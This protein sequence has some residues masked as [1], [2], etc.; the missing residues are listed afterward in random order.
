VGSAAV[1]R[2]SVALCSNPR[3]TRLQRRLRL[4]VPLPLFEAYL[5]LVVTRL[6]ERWF[7]SLKE[8]CVWLEN[9]ESSEQAKAAV[10]GWIRFYNSERPHQ[11]LEYMSPEQFRAQQQEQVA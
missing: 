11:S 4:L 6:I 3:I 2:F 9:F 8:E 7:R 1:L 5:T 10:A